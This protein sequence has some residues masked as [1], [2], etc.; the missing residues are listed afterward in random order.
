MSLD[1]WI[2]IVVNFWAMP[3]G[4]FDDMCDYLSTLKDH[5]EWD[6]SID[7][8]IADIYFVNPLDAVAFKLKFKV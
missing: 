6:L 5:E 4:I 1:N 7:G 2:K 3:D 8:G